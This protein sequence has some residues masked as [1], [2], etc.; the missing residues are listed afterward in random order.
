MFVTGRMAI[1]LFRVIFAMVKAAIVELLSA[2]LKLNFSILLPYPSW[3]IFLCFLAG[4]GYSMALYYRNARDNFPW[5]LLFLL[6]A[7]RFLAVGITAFLLLAPLVEKRLTH[8][9]DP[10]LLFVQDNS[11]SLL[12]AA[13]TGFYHQEYLPALESFLQQMEEEHSSRLYTFGEGFREA[14]RAGEIDFQERMTNMS[15]VFD[16]IDA[17]YSNRN[18]G[19]VVLAGDGL[20][21]RGLHP[22]YV[23]SAKPYPVYTMALGE[24]LPRRD[25]V[26][27]R[28]RH[29]RI[30]YLGNEFPV[31]I[32]I[33]AVQ[34]DGLDS[35]LTVSK[36][37]EVLFSESLS[38]VSDRHTETIGLQLEATEAGMQ[39]FHAA[40]EP[41]SG[42]VS[43]EN[44]NKDFFIEVIDGRQEVL[45]LANSPHPDVGAIGQSL[46]NNDSYHVTKVLAKEFDQDPSAYDLIIMHQLPSQNHPMRELLENLEQSGTSVLY[47]IGSQTDLPAFNSLAHGLTIE[48]RS[49]ELAE[50]LG[51]YHSGFAL[52]SLPERTGRLVEMLPPLYVPFA[53]YLTPSDAHILLKQQIGQVL[54]AQPLILFTA[55]EGRKTG[56]IAGEGIWRWRLHAYMREN[57][58][59]AFDGLLSRMVQYL[60]LKEDRRHLRVETQTLIH[61]NEGAVFEA[62]LYNASYQL[63]NEP[64]VQLSITSQEGHLM[65]YE[66]GRTA[67]AYRLSAGPFPPGSY[68]YEATASLGGEVHTARG[69][70]N[71]SSLDLEGLRT[72]ADHSLLY[73]MAANTGAIMVY[74]EQWDLLARHINERDDI[75]PKI[76]FTKEFVEVIH[77]RLLFFVILL[78]LGLEWFLRKRNGSY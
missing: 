6:S 73:Q 61:E 31:E 39:R 18:I 33:E 26:L 23:A 62:E 44:N 16:E 2:A 63:V 52:F 4:L 19:A 67:N 7:F 38:F 12:L 59:L 10:L 72:R 3:F 17:R 54:T 13:D 30:T 35:R 55:R 66:M 75:G 15:Q 28:I 48:A 46:G 77:F 60:A 45:I 8:V 51:S 53:N 50:A 68:S 42:E 1:C 49:E 34:S 56:L 24:P 37:G 43:T 57:S 29:N 14:G 9:D 76:Y 32:D 78:L 70:F 36:D 47:I 69:L 11:R 27:R 58:H 41:V 65:E 5:P 71:V 22:L 40:L 20:F 21:N 64:G 74:P 25:L